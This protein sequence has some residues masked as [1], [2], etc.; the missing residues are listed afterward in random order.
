MVE[1]D[2]GVDDEWSSFDPRGPEWEWVHSDSP[3]DVRE[4]Q[5]ARARGYLPA[6]E[7]PMWCFLPAIWP[8]GARA[9]VR[10]TRV[11]HLTRQR[12]GESPER[13]P[14]N[15]ADYADIERET[16]AFLTELG[17]PPRPA[18]RIWL[19]RAPE[20]FGTP[21]DVMDAISAGWQASGGPDMAT[22]ESWNTPT[23]G[24]ASSSDRSSFSRYDDLGLLLEGAGRGSAASAVVPRSR[25][26]RWPA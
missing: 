4:V 2:W 26:S 12:T 15:T 20:G 18:G 16:N 22:P 6:D 24:C 19:L 23:A 9:W 5:A 13:L 3:E 1:A 10:D 7:A 14:W 25:K 21:E 17:L 8:S 11:R